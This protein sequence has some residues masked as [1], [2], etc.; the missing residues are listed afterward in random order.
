MFTDSFGPR[1]FSFFLMTFVWAQNGTIYSWIASAVPRPTA[2]RAAAF[3]FVNS[4][5][6][7]ASVWTPFTYRVQDKP[8]YRLALG[9]NIGLMVIAGLLSIWL[10]FILIRQNRELD[11]LEN[12]TEQ[13]S[14]KQLKKLEKTA[15]VQ[16]LSTGEARRLQK[17]YRYVI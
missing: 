11:A 12:E 14:E 8:H 7:S 3:A 5:G 1:Y 10:R 13:L 9:I 15:E 16:G 2:K 6:N 17:G 4:L